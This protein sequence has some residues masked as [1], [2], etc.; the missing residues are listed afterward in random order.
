[1]SSGGDGGYQPGW[2]DLRAVFATLACGLVVWDGVATT[3]ACAEGALVSGRAARSLEEGSLGS[4][5]GAS[6]SQALNTRTR[7]TRTTT[8]NATRHSSTKHSPGT[9]CPVCKNISTCR[10]VQCG[11]VKIQKTGKPSHLYRSSRNCWKP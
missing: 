6:A 3:V 9:G 4:T 1:M 8:N 11:T 5:A 10:R 7:S 2:V